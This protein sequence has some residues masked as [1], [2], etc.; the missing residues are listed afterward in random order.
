MKRFAWLIL[1]VF[2]LTACKKYRLSQPAY[3]HFGWNY[4]NQPASG[5]VQFNRLELYLSDFEVVGEREEGEDILMK[6]DINSELISFTGNGSMSVGMD[7]PVGD[8]KNFTL[9][10]NIPEKSP[11]LIIHGSLNKGTEVIPIRVEWYEKKVLPFKA[12]VDFELKKKKDYDVN[13]NLNVQKLLETVSANQWAFA[14]ITNENGV[15]TIVINSNSNSAIFQDI[16][17]SIY[18][19]IYLTLP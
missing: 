3:L 14:D 11:G 2:C 7:V 12:T 17:N 8:Y 19:S 10:M 9:T 18:Q 1:C 6:K 16:D 15:S 13:M 5:N 4:I